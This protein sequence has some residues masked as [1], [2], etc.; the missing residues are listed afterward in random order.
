MVKLRDKATGLLV[1]C[2]DKL[3]EQYLAKGWVR[4]GEYKA[5]KSVPSKGNL[6][7]KG[8]SSIDVE[9]LAEA[10]ANIVLARLAPASEPD[11]ELESETVDSPDGT[12][13]NPPEDETVAGDE[14]V[15][16]GQTRRTIK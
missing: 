8:E 13:E 1:T 11:A 7:V 5:P 15:K 6:E 14:P 16:R 2:D 9:A 10:V 4:A 3:A 12:N